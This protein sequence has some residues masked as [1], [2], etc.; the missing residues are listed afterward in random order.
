MFFFTNYSLASILT[1]L[2]ALLGLILVNELTRRSKWVSIAVFIALPTFLTAFVWR[3]GDGSSSSSTWFAWVKTYS[4]LAGVIGFMAIRFIPKLQTNKFALFFPAFILGFN[5]L[6]AVFRDIECFSKGSFV[7]GGLTIIGGPW[8]LM[9]AAAG[10]ILII[11]MTGWTGIKIAKTKSQDMIWP[12]QLW[13]WIIAYDLWNM[14]YCY[15]C[16]STRSFYAGF[17]LL[18][19]CTLPA[20]FIRRG[21]WLQHRAQTLALWGMFSLTFAYGKSPLFGITTT[22]NPASLFTL[23]ALALLANVAVLVYVI[24]KA[25]KTK[26]NFIKQDLFESLKSY[27]QALAENNLG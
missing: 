14:A 1:A 16:L 20:F 6:E 8:N 7:E 11:T 19:S 4:A 23:S 15:N 5:I 22:N 3:A 18:L 21:A 25:N 26:R 10:I 9:N 27:R 24:Y 13:F 17:I 12:D 2:A